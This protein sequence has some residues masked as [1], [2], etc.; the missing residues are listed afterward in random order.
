MGRNAMSDEEKEGRRRVLL[1]AAHRLYRERGVLPP[2]ADIA[3]AAG[4]AKGTVY[5][6]FRTK[7]KIFVALLEDALGS[8]FAR[9]LPAL[10]RLPRGGRD[11]AKAFADHYV[12][13]IADSADLLPLAALANAVL[14]QNLPVE[15][16]RRFKTGL[17][18]ALGQAGR[19]LEQR[20]GLAPGGSGETLLLHTYSLTL[21][22]WQALSYP[23]PLRALLQEESLRGLARD[24][25]PELHIGVHRLWLGYFAA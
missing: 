20:T 16:M 15:P 18:R 19:H 14:E 5:L 13:L 4:L 7:E 6:Y 17:A 11:T 1:A 23:E 3:T 22:L 2:V 24:F 10:D 8:L 12:R 9:L 25:E 21:G